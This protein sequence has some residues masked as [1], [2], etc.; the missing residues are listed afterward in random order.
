MKRVI[1][2][3]LALSI[4]V[5]F[6]FNKNDTDGNNDIYG[7][8]KVT[9]ILS[10]ESVL[11]TKKDGY[12]PRIEFKTDGTFSL[13]LDEN[14]CGGSFA[15]TKSK[16][17]SFSGAECTEICC[18]SGF[19]QKIARMLTHIKSYHFEKD[20]LKLV[21]PGWGWMELEKLNNQYK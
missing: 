5:I 1:L 12:N 3:L 7:K 14:S 11:Y 18:D 2:I 16:G 17:I 21:V 8:W 13:R 20:K 10:V 9:Q 15:L 6:S 19:S 4:F